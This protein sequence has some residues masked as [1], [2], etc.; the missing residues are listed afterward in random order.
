MGLHCNQRFVSLAET[1]VTLHVEEVDKWSDRWN[2]ALG[3]HGKD[4]TVRP[5]F[6]IRGQHEHDLPDG[7]ED[8]WGHNWVT[9]EEILKADYTQPVYGSCGH[10]I[11]SSWAE[12]LGGGTPWPIE[13]YGEY[14]ALGATHIF[15]HFNR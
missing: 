9:L 3:Y 10:E 13:H 7:D 4:G 8:N 14:T 2:E 6:P 1:T 5:L 12:Y 11:C 15:Y